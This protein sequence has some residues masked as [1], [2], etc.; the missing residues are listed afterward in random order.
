MIAGVV[1]AAG[2]SSRM[3][4][5][6]AL[7]ELSG[8]TFL[9][10]I[11]TALA[12]GGCELLVVVAGNDGLA[13]AVEVKR[14]AARAGAHVVVNPDPGSE[15][16]ESLRLAIRALPAG[17]E[18][19]LA[20]PVDSPKLRSETVA[21]LIAA[22]RDGAEVA[23]PTVNG[24]RGHPILFAGSAM[25]ELLEPLPEGARTV[26]RRHEEDLVHVPAADDGIL[27]DVDTPEEYARLTERP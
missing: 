22:R 19:I 1:L 25:A 20:T 9:E 18:G 7:L 23:V 2:R 14:I 11:L 12:G 3:G 21:H 13:G 8:R 15:Q 27:L 17:V 5:P 24:R 26:L 10:G 16:V 6:K 4:A